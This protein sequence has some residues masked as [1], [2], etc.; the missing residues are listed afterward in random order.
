MEASA[1]APDWLAAC[2]RIVVELRA[3][4][5]EHPGTAERAVELGRGEGGDRT[6]MVDDAAERLIF[7]E[8]EALHAAGHEFTAVSEE[9]GVVAYGASERRV[10]IDPIDGSRNAKRGLWPYTVSIAVSEPPAPGPVGP[11]MADVSFGFVYD[12]GLSEEWTAQRGSGAWLNER[13]LYCDGGERRTP[14]GLLELVAIESARPDWLVA[15]LPELGPLVSRLRAFGSI[16]FALC[17]LAACRVDGMVTLWD[18]RSF[19]A[20]AA[21]LIVRESGGQIAFTAA[22]EPLGLALDLAARSPIV[23]ARTPQTLAA[24]AGVPARGRVLPSS[25]G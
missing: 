11:S 16:A 17:Q 3:M 13:A 10:V 1:T 15:G 6:L 22:A 7:A 19:D 24:L 8:L 21:Q 12:F 14:N 4:L 20:A 23:A 5:A 18:S 9:R 25:G 2:R